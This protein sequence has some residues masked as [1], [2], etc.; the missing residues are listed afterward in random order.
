MQKIYNI[1]EFHCTY[2]LDLSAVDEGEEKKNQAEQRVPS[3]ETAC[4]PSEE[5]V[6]SV[7]RLISP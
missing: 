7:S 4:F 1:D 5:A 3:H 6:I 2:H